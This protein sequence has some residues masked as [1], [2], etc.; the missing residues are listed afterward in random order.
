MFLTRP[1]K[2]PINYLMLSDNSRLIKMYVWTGRGGE[3]IV[4]RKRERGAVEGAGERV[5]A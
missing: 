2:W 5:F 4:R 3:D 1:D